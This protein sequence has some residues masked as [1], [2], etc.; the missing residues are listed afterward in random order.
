MDSV[1]NVGSAKA[2]DLEACLAAEPDL[3]ILPKESTGLCKDSY[4]HGYSNN[5]CQPGSHDELVEMIKLI[6]EVTNSNDKAT[7]MT[8]KY[9][10]I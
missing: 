1:G 3:V 5:C 9:D 2:F 6:G 10:E 8:D 4:R 7:A